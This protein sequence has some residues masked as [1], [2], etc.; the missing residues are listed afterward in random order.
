MQAAK[1]IATPIKAKAETIFSIPID[2]NAAVVPQS[3]KCPTLGFHFLKSLSSLASLNHVLQKVVEHISMWKML[4]PTKANSGGTNISRNFQKITV[5]FV[6][7][8][9]SICVIDK[10]KLFIGNF[11]KSFVI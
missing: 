1:A 3:G 7:F 4:I 11:N 6:H 9:H 8:M 10:S 5:V 2:G